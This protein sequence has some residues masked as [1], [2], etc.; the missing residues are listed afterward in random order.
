MTVSLGSLARAV[1]LL[2]PTNMWMLDTGKLTPGEKIRFHSLLRE[3]IYKWSRLNAKHVQFMCEMFSLSHS[4][5]CFAQ[6]IHLHTTQT[7]IE[8]Q[9]EQREESEMRVNWMGIYRRTPIPPTF[10]ISPF[11]LLRTGS[12]YIANIARDSTDTLHAMLGRTTIGI[13]PWESPSAV[14]AHPIFMW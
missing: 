7:Y 9:K 10:A 4:P 8:V 5:L 3:V 2:Y 6:F 12:I 1:P 11:F 13:S 14:T